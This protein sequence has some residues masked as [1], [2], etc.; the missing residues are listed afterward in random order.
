MRANDLFSLSFPCSNRFSPISFAVC[1]LSLSLFLCCYIYADDCVLCALCM[2]NRQKILYV[3][4]EH[5]IV[6]CL[7][8]RCCRYRCMH[9]CRCGIFLCLFVSIFGIMFIFMQILFNGILDFS[10]VLPPHNSFIQDEMVPFF[11]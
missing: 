8:L 7:P 11:Q 3:G 9:E 1:R 10:I 2:R 5:S 6:T 4:I